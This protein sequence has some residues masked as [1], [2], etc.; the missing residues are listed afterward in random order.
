MALLCRASPGASCFVLPLRQSEIYGQSLKIRLKTAAADAGG[1]EHALRCERAVR[2]RV[3]V[4]EVDD[5]V[6]AALD[7]R[8]AAFVAREQGD[9]DTTALQ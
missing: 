6:N 2:C 3:L 7:D 9:V 8:F 4:R 1:S 5:L